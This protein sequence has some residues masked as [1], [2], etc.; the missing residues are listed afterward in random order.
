[1]PP[2][3]QGSMTSKTDQESNGLHRI[4]CENRRG[5]R[6]RQS[7]YLPAPWPEERGSEAIP[8]EEDD[9]TGSR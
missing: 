4:C 5:P 3:V 1:M 7:R 8:P 9:M 6:W 2:K